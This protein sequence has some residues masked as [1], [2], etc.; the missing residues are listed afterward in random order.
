MIPIY[1]KTPEFQEPQASLYYLVTAAGLFLVKKT[2]LFQSVTA[3]DQVAGLEQQKPSLALAFE[4]I[5][6]TIMESVYGFFDWAYRQFESEAIL[7]LYYSPQ[8]RVFLLDAPPQTL[9]RYRLG[10]RWL[11]E[12]RLEYGS[13]ERPEGF[14]RLGDFHSHGDMPPFFSAT[15]DR[16]DV[17]DGLRVV[18]GNLD[19]ARPDVRVS[20]VAGGTR[21]PLDPGTSIEDYESPTPPPKEWMKR[22]ICKYEDDQKTKVEFRANGYYRS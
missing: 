7:F 11:T 20:F 22:V 9:F 18:M 12:G 16:D 21:F 5:P 17:A 3:V 19:R 14:V 6:R 13:L 10:S 1:V 8:R 4:R 15:D 2:A